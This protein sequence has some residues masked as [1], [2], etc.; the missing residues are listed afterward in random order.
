MGCHCRKSQDKSQLFV[1]SLS[2]PKDHRAVPWDL[3]EFLQG[4]PDFYPRCIYCVLPYDQILYERF[5]RSPRILGKLTSYDKLAVGAETSLIPLYPIDEI[6]EL[7]FESG[8]RFRVAQDVESNDPVVGVHQQVPEVFSLRIC[9]IICHLP[10]VAAPL[11]LL[12]R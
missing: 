6:L 1:L 11:Y 8:Y 4:C 10:S 7:V 2:L 3:P 9:A 12:N 5:R